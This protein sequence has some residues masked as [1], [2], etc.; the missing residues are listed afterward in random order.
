MR[1]RDEFK[2]LL[3]TAATTSKNNVVS[4]VFVYKKKDALKYSIQSYEEIR[5]LVKV[6]DINKLPYINDKNENEKSIT[7]ANE[8]TPPKMNY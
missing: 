3:K 5:K 6:F 1:L 8:L 2:I 7:T 4:N